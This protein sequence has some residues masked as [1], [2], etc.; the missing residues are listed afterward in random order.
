MQDQLKRFQQRVHNQLAALLTFENHPH[1]PQRLIDAMR[2]A[3][4]N[5]GKRLRPALIYAVAEALNIPLTQVDKA[6]CAIE[7]IHS[8]SL[9]HD[10]LPAMDDDDLRRGQPTCHIQYDEATAILVGDA[11]QTLAFSILSE[12]AALSADVR[13]EMIR[14]LSRTAGINGMIGGQMLDIASEGQNIE[15]ALLEQLHNMKTGALIQAAL[16][17]GAAASPLYAEIKAPLAE[18]GKTIGL[19]FQVQDDILDIE[20]DTDTLGKPQGSDLAADKSTYPKL[21]GLDG[22]KRYRNELIEQAQQQ[23]RQLPFA[24][25]FLAQLIDYIGQRNH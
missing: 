22:A 1:V 15:L 24:S 14:I 4:L 11:Q 5:S 23:Y 6:A 10:D 9:V 20:G 16:L 17:M 12:D 21:L 25:P 18:L 7:L 13:L 3:T 19:A 8:Y 2:Y